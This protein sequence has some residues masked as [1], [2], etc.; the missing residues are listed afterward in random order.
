MNLLQPSAGRNCMKLLILSRSACS[1]SP[2]ILAKGRSRE[3]I[4]DTTARTR[5]NNFIPITS[6]AAVRIS[7]Q[8]PLNLK[9]RQIIV[10]NSDAASFL[11]R[12]EPMIDRWLVFS[13]A[14]SCAGVGLRV[15]GSW[16]GSFSGTATFQGFAEDLARLRHCTLGNKC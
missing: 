16:V 13:C 8:I 2:G 10:S 9:C 14:F 1:P 6:P 4:A 7:P 12:P 3:D 15:L 11:H 5:A